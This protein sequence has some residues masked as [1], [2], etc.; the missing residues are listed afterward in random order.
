MGTHADNRQAELFVERLGAHVRLTHLERHFGSAQIP[1]IGSDERDELGGNT[2]TAI[3]WV[4]SDF[5][6]LHLASDD[7]PAAIANELLPVVC[8]PPRAVA[9][10]QFVSNKRRGP[11]IASHAFAF[12]S[13]NAGS[14]GSIERTIRNVG[15]NVGDFCNHG[16]T[17]LD[18][19][20]NDIGMLHTRRQIARRERIS[21]LG[22]FFRQANALVFLG[23][24][25]ARIYGQKH[26]RVARAQRHRG[27]ACVRASGGGIRFSMPCVSRKIDITRSKA[28]L[29]R[30]QQTRTRHRPQ[31]F[32]C[33]GTQRLEN[34]SVFH[35]G[36]AKNSQIA[37]SLRK[38]RL[39]VGDPFARNHGLHYGIGRKAGNLGIRNFKQRGVHFLAHGIGRNEH[40][41]A[42]PFRPR[43]PRDGIERRD[44]IQRH[45]ERRSSAFGRGHAN[46]HT[47]E[48]AGTA[49]A[50]DRRDIALGHT[51]FGKRCVDLVQKDGVARAM[52][53]NFP[54]SNR[55]NTRACNAS[56]TN[57]H[58]FIR[59]IKC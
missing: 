43:A 51:R 24:G 9:A 25:K 26:R 50:H 15:R 7:P 42:H 18:C 53:G 11:R 21:F 29:G 33:D 58:D 44:A 8:R 35:Q 3:R 17:I 41:A 1:R 45:F 48:A 38:L 23:I 20:R 5:Q 6:N 56:N 31:A 12:H 57:G 14:V 10:R 13:G 28:S 4:G 59:R 30:K 37:G 54:T 47:R 36:V 34:L 49:T 55:L 52:H 2:A 32:V 27:R 19:R 16:G 46:A 40:A 22:G 39:L